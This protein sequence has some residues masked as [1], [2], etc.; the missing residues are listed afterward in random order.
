MFTRKRGNLAAYDAAL[1]DMMVA[2]LSAYRGES[3]EKAF[4]NLTKNTTPNFGKWH[5][6]ELAELIARDPSTAAARLAASE[7]AKRDSWQTP[8]KWSLGVSFFALAISVWA[9]ARTF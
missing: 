8:A 3:Y 6:D 9:F 7:V 2:S 5:D 1:G 4:D